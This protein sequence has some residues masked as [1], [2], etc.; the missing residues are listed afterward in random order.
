MKEDIKLFIDK[1]TNKIINK[2]LINKTAIDKLQEK[3]GKYKWKL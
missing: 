3:K 1:N 2:Y